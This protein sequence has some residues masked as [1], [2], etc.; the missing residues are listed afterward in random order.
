MLDS[1][2]G[3]MEGENNA[4]H[5]RDYAAASG[6]LNL[7][8]CHLKSLNPCCGY[9]VLDEERLAGKA[10]ADSIVQAQQDRELYAVLAACGGAGPG[11]ARRCWLFGKG[12]DCGFLESG[13]S[14][15][16]KAPGLFAAQDFDCDDTAWSGSADRADCF[17]E[18]VA[19]LQSDRRG[20]RIYFAPI[21]KDDVLAAALTLEEAVSSPTSSM[22]SVD[23]SARGV[24]MQLVDP[25]DSIWHI[26]PGGRFG[27]TVAS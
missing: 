4:Y 15:S 23:R 21:R 9:A 13:A 25:L 14:L 2:N 7:A 12:T 22:D 3:H 1:A 17:G 20:C 16:R 26:E 5:R 6:R 8:Q 19:S 27:W 11:Q 18:Q 24:S 10:G